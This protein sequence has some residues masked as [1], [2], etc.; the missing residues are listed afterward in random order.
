MDTLIGLI[1]VIQMRWIVA[2]QFYNEFLSNWYADGMVSS[3]N[4]ARIINVYYCISIMI[5]DSM[6]A[7]LLVL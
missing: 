5:I 3:S 1:K 2:W 6:T 7:M 4:Q